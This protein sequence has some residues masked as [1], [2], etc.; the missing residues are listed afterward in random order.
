MTRD[1]AVNT[2]TEPPKIFPRLIVSSRL[3]KALVSKP[4]LERTTLS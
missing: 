1:I 2:K 3:I 4:R